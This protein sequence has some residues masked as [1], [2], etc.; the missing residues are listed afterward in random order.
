MKKILG[1]LFLCF[2]V[3]SCS[4][5]QEDL[6]NYKKAIDATKNAQYE[7]AIE[8][9]NNALNET[10]DDEMK[11]KILYNTG[12]CYGIMKDFDKE[13]EYF[14]KSLEAYSSF[15]PALCSLGYYYYDNK[16]LD[17]S[18]KLYEQLIKVNPEH[19]EAYYRIALIQKELGNEEV[20]MQFMQ[21]AAELESPEA[22][23][24]LLHQSNQEGQDNKE[25]QDNQ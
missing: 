8:L 16:D 14:K 1:C 23:E 18:L 11:A 19:E 7:Q 10:N 2:L 15:Q 4:S 21:K 6:S 17:N 9:F 20:A 13:I 12:F 22:K 3:V 24:F 25:E 5:K